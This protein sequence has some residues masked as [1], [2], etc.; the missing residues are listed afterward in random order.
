MIDSRDFLAAKR[1]AEQEALVPPGLK[2]IV[3]GGLNFNDH[4]LVWSARSD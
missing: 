1:R 3:T 2:I 4:R